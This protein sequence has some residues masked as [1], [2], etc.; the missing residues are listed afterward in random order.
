MLFIR[1]FIVDVANNTITIE[2]ILSMPVVLIIGGGLAGAAAA[3]EIAVSGR[4]TLIVEASDRLGGKVR[5]YGCKASD[6]C[7]N[8]GVCLTKGLW[9]SVENDPLIEIKFNTKLVDLTGNKGSYT[10]ALR[11]GGVIDYIDN[12]SDVIVATGF[13]Q[14]SKKGG[15]FTEIGEALR[16]KKGSVI[17]GSDIEELFKDRGGKRLFTKPPGSIAFIQCYGSRDR[18]ENIACSKVCCAYSTRA[19]KVLKLFYPECRIVFYYMEMQQVMAGDY[20][21]EL[22]G[23]G[24]EFIKCRPIKITAGQPAYIEF[25]NPET[26]RR[27]RSGFD[28]IVLSDGIAPASDAGRVAEICGLGQTGD[29]FLKYVNGMDDV[30]STGIYIAGCAGG[31]ARI[32]DVYADAVAAAKAILFEEERGRAR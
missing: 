26:G 14:V 27:E 21:D 24:M 17:S 4:R 2:E 10:A 19:A 30:K 31:P 8:C 9:G 13:E 5:D 7:N 23:L 29:G 12:I 1:P 25:D 28:L 32:E 11:S 16:D 22:K 6:K 18:S 15:G 20:F 3:R